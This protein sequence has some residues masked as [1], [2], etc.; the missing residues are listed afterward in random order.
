MYLARNKNGTIGRRVRSMGEQAV[1]ATPAVASHASSTILSYGS[2]ERDQA[3]WQAKEKEFQRNLE[4]QQ[5]KILADKAKKAQERR[6][7]E[8]QVLNEQQKIAI[9]PLEDALKRQFALAA[10]SPET[11]RVVKSLKAD[12]Y[13]RELVPAPQELPKYG[14]QSPDFNIFGIVGN[15]LSR[16]GRYGTVTDF[17]RI[18]KGTELDND[19]VKVVAGTMIRNIS[20]TRRG[21]GSSMYSPTVLMSTDQYVPTQ[22]DVST[23]V[24]SPVP[25]GAQSMVPAAQEQASAKPSGLKKAA[26]VG[27][28]ALGIFFLTKD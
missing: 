2:L 3:Y 13:D 4:I 9:N 1:V 22:N 27:V 24:M 20:E 26:L 28:A 12:F 6:S 21:M 5:Q 7:L 8:A 25:T 18:V 19:E 11:E 17:D 15:P 16:N 10:V 23:Q 14:A